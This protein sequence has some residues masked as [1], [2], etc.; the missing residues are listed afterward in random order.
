M[1]KTTSL[2]LSTP[3]KK[4]NLVTAIQDRMIL[5]P[6]DSISQVLGLQ[7]CTTVAG[8]CSTGDGTLS[9]VCN[10]QAFYPLCRSTDLDAVKATGQAKYQEL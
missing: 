8:I 7:M 6:P 3:Y 10:R 5:L 1:H 2:I 4:I 9:F